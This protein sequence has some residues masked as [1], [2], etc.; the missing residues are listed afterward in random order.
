LGK[1]REQKAKG[2]IWKQANP[3]VFCPSRSSHLGLSGRKKREE[4]GKKKE[5]G[6]EKKANASV[7]GVL[8]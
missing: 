7:H 5:V 4:K 8:L 1:E 2:S 6:R 3:V